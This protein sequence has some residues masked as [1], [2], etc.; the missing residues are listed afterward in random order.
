MSEGKFKLTIRQNSGS[1]FDVEV[2]SGATVQDLKQA[3]A[4]PAG[5]V[6]E[7]IRLIF[8]GKKAKVVIDRDLGESGY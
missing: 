3:C 8:K 2:E 6:A 1:Q 7:E 4:T 5:I